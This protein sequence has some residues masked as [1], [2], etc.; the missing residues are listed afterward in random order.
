MRQLPGIIFASGVCALSAPAVAHSQNSS[1]YVSPSCIN[2]D[3]SQACGAPVLSPKAPHISL[4]A[5]AHKSQLVA[6]T[7]DQQGSLKGSIEIS[8]PL[9]FDD[10]YLGDIPVRILDQNYWLPWDRL[11]DLIKERLTTEVIEKLENIAANGYLEGRRIN[12]D[13]ILINY[14]PQLL[15]IEI[16]PKLGARETE[17]IN[18]NARINRQNVDYLDP[19][20]FSVFFN[21][22]IT[23]LYNWSGNNSSQTNLKPF[24]SLDIG[25][26]IGGE[27]GIAFLSEFLFD[28]NDSF[29]IQRNETLFVYD[30]NS[31]LLRFTLGDIQPRT[32]SLQSSSSIIG[33]S[34]ERF[35]DLE[36]E[37]Q[38]TPRFESSFRL[39]RT[40]NVQILQNGSLRRELDLGP[41]Q[42]DLRDLAL[43]QG[44][45]N[46]DLIIKDESGGERTISSRSY[47]D[48]NLLERGIWDFSVNAGFRSIFG[49]TGLSYT[50][51]I[52]AS[53]FLRRGVSKTL[54]VGADLQGDESGGNGG[55]SALW[56]SPIGV[57]QGRASTSHYDFFGNGYSA[58][59]AITN[60]GDFGLSGDAT[61]AINLSGEYNTRRFRTLPTSAIDISVSSLGF[62]NELQT[63]KLDMNGG[64]Q[65]TKDRWSFTTSL[66]Y[67]KSYNGLRDTYGI[68]AGINYRLSKDLNLA[69][70]TRHSRNL[71]REETGGRMRLTW[72]FNRARGITVGYDSIRNEA[73][74]EYR[75]TS[76]NSV[77]ALSYNFRGVNDLSSNSHNVRGEAFY[78]GNRFEALA[79]HQVRKEP[80]RNNSDQVSPAS[81][82]SSLAFVDGAFAIGRPVRETYAIV[83]RHPNLARKKLFIDP[84][85][86]NFR[87]STDGLG[88]ALVS[89][90]NAYGPTSFNYDVED[91]PP[92]Y[93]L[94]DGKFHVRAPLN[95]GYKVRVG[96]DA[97]YTLIGYVK[98]KETDEGLPYLSGRLES[99]DDPAAEP[100]TAFTNRNGRLAATGLVPGK[101]RLTLNTD[102]IF[103]H[104]I[105]I[106]DSDSTLVNI[107]DLR[108]NIENSES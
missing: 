53:G 10:V 6:P 41:G 48:F 74:L 100:V 97:S 75:K 26:R 8:L 15:Q 58:G 62:I 37:R 35:F 107:G 7:E 38:F 73:E 36:P 89:Q 67:L 94:G 83:E 105:E 98:N 104:T 85:G 47:F 57:I 80:G 77:G 14:N 96:S 91:L 65:L 84:D 18:F 45:N 76:H 86:K 30:L 69:L 92:G 20:K 24:G 108:V 56:A 2:I 29:D 40:S 64:L 88:H 16:S 21:P 50:D 55:V 44:S 39:D 71:I 106:T 70:T 17:V 54:T 63:P 52:V 78:V 60:R 19:G 5:E 93:D 95:A 27:K 87:A 23:T 12:L 82:R 101:Y 22:A 51:E 79:Q 43:S 32:D 72:R 25:G 9:L 31:K 59:F 102:P 3:V 42:Y 1:N 33:V 81:I 46:L 13:L 66:D 11:R 68:S 90:L 61:W 99:L 49:Q 4:L 28:T 34:I 103:T